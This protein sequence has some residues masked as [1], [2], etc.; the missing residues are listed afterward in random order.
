RRDVRHRA[1][2]LHSAGALRREPPGPD[3]RRAGPG[4]DHGPGAPHRRRARRRVPRRPDADGHAVRPQP[5]R[6]LALAR[7]TRRGGRLRS[8]RA[9]ARPGPRGPGTLTKRRWL[10]D[11]AWLP[12]QGLCREVLIAADGDRFTTVTPSA[13]PATPTA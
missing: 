3:Q 5:D 1:G 9:R 12:G 6:R 8:R 7:R 4:R 13:T 2:V 11:L 10:A